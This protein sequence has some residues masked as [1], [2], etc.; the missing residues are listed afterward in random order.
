[1]YKISDFDYVLPEPLIAQHPLACRDQSNLLVLEKESGKVSHK[2]FSD[3][4]DF[5]SPSDVLVL[6]DTKVIPARLLGHKASG[7]KVE[8]FFLKLLQK[9]TF[10]ALV[11][12]SSRV[13]ENTAIFIGDDGV[14]PVRNKISNGVKLTVYEA[15][16]RFRGKIYPRPFTN[17]K[18]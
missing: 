6:N 4:V 12:P 1:M 14:N 13:R 2:K 7:G 9:N 15:R 5:L 16:G 11:K 8:I 18:I 3:I 10:L 17:I